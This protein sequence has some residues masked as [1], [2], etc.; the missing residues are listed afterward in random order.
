[1]DR[2]PGLKICL[3]HGGGY[4]ASYAPRADYALLTDPSEFNGEFP[5]KMPSEYLKQMYCDSLVFSSEA[6]RHLVAVCGSDHVVMGSDHPI[7]WQPNAVDHILNVPMLSDDEKR[8]I[9]GGTAAKLL[10][11]EQ[12][13]PGV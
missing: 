7:P 9:L 3:A 1:L 4:W 2:Y 8:A 13:V 6:L 12:S 11:I 10:G 5:K